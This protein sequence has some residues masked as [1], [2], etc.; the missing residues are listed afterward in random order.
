MLSA[1]EG[2]GSD[3]GGQLRQKWLF[4]SLFSSQ[5]EQAICGS[6]ETEQWE[7][8]QTTGFGFIKIRASPS[9]VDSFFLC[10][11]K[12]FIYLFLERDEGMEKEREKNID[13]IPLV[14]PHMG[15]WLTT[16]ACALTRNRTGSLSV[17][18]TMPNPLS[19]TSQG[20]SFLHLLTQQTHL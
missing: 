9:W 11:F 13:R 4:S 10:F 16:Q 5:K 12:D 15:T 6:L 8:R 14:G 3:P 19:H 17:C 18:S 7:G 1:E 2:E 20:D